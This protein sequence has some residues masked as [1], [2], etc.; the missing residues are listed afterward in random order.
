MPVI[1]GYCNREGNLSEGFANLEGRKPIHTNFDE[2]VPYN[3]NLSKES[4][5]FKDVANKVK[6]FYYRK[7][8]ENSTETFSIVS[9]NII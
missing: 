8:I 2:A 7:N 5:Q 3:L 1:I 4:T 9:I 6:E